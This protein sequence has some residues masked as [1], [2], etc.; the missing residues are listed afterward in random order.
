ML[1]PGGK[2]VGSFTGTCLRVDQLVHSNTYITETNL[3]YPLFT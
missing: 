3:S 1:T 2:G